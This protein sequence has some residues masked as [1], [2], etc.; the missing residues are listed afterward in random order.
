MRN[1]VVLISLLVG[2]SLWYSASSLSSNVSPPRENWWNW[3]GLSS[4]KDNLSAVS[5][6]EDTFDWSLVDDSI[7]SRD[8]EELGRRDPLGSEAPTPAPELKALEEFHRRNIQAHPDS[9]DALRSYAHFL[10]LDDRFPE[11]L[12]ALRDAL[13]LAPDAKWTAFQEKAEKLVSE[14]EKNPNLLDGLEIGMAMSEV[15]WP[16]VSS[17]S[18]AVVDP[19]TAKFSAQ[20]EKD[21]QKMKEKYAAFNSKYEMGEEET[22]ALLVARHYRNAEFYEE[23]EQHF[24]KAHSAYP[25]SPKALESYARFLIGRGRIEEATRLVRA[26]KERFPTYASFHIIADILTKPLEPYSTYDSEVSYWADIMED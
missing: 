1:R 26:G 14:S 16:A 9:A 8:L 15:T 10:A 12:R 24:A 6:E 3:L 22:D 17:E 19:E 13:R 5:A 20:V 4:V 7:R 21:R 25:D 11:A 2:L 23:A 18:P